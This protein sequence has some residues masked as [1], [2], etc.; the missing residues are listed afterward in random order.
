M[1][2]YGVAH[3]QAELEYAKTL[4]DIAEVA[5]FT[6]EIDRA[7]G[8]SMMALRTFRNVYGET[9]MQVSRDGSQTPCTLHA[10]A[11]AGGLPLKRQVTMRALRVRNAC[12]LVRAAHQVSQ[13]YNKLAVLSAKGGTK[14]DIKEAKKHLAS[15]L[16]IV[17]QIHGGSAQQVAEKGDPYAAEA[18]WYGRRPLNARLEA[19]SCR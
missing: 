8:L 19:S 11:L 10:R 9:S 1:P 6:D 14:E 12:S 13:V 7:K 3:A 4:I 5:Q 18:L 17:Q 2:T 15:S 16:R